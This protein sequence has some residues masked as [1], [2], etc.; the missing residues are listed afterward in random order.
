MTRKIL[1]WFGICLALGV[2][3]LGV[4][5]GLSLGGFGDRFATPNPGQPTISLS[6]GGQA[7]AQTPADGIP[8]ATTGSGRGS[9]RHTHIV[10]IA[11]RVSPA[12]VSIGVTKTQ[13]IRQY[14]PF[15]GDLFFP[16]Y[17]TRRLKRN[18]PYLGSGFIIDK[19]GHVITNYHVIENA[20]SINVTLTDR[21]TYTAR[22]LDA[23]RYV[24]IALLQIEQLEPDED[25]PTLP[26]GDSD[27]IMI[28][29]TALAV[30]N[31]FG[32]LI[33]DPRP[34]VSV[35]VVSAV[36]RSFQPHSEGR[37][38]QDMI[39]SDAAINPGNSGG[40]LVNLDGEAI[41]INTFIFS[42]SGDSASVGFSIPV[43][44]AR[45]IVDE[46]LEFGKIRSLR[47]DFDVLSLTDYIIQALDLNVRHGALVRS[48]DI[49][50]AAEAA[51]L[52]PG[53][54]IVQVD[55]KPIEDDQAL[56][57]NFLTRTVGEKMTLKIVRQGN[58]MT[59]T[60]Q[61]TEARP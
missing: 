1:Q 36:Q 14:D 11:E 31:P 15:G 19:K 10:D 25:L 17:L 59:L 8:N 52:E 30:G 41:G 42:R 33:A 55:D 18:F 24:D 53:D 37:I 2:L 43:N 45:R 16:P 58:P 27:D 6:P 44:R 34:S 5:L 57:A 23:D 4:G 12:V 9:A 61:I 26:L 29:E 28:G 47:L 3:G 50:G 21:R 20:S 39:Q 51:G 60:Y 7:W 49:G 56:L 38:Y 22:V 35:G 32:P 54:V 46:I 13:I 40:P 48:I